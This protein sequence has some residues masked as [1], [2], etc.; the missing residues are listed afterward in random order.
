MIILEDKIRVGLYQ[1][2]GCQ[3]KFVD[4]LNATEKYE[5]MQ[6]DTSEINPDALLQFLDMKLF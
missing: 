6:F 1:K 3:R 2:F 5:S 4:D